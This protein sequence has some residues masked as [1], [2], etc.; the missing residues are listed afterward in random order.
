MK[1]RLAELWIAKDA[2]ASLINLDLP[3]KQAYWLGK[4]S[5]LFVKEIEAIEAVRLKL[6]KKYST[7]KEGVWTVDVN[8]KE[9]YTEFIEEFS[10]VLEEEVDIDFKKIPIESIFEATRKMSS[11]EINM[12]RWIIDDPEGV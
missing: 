3:T 2:L 12:L 9:K 5:K 8:D 11:T 7:E 1:V 10:K 4:D 6:V